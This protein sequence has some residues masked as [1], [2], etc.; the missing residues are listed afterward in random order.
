MVIIFSGFISLSFLFGSWAPQ[1]AYA[2]CTRGTLTDTDCDG[3][4]DNWEV[5]KS[6][7][8]NRD[9]K[10]ISLPGANPNHKNLY[11]EIDFMLPHAPRSD[12]V[13]DVVTAFRNA[14]VFNPDG[15]AG[16]TVNILVDS[17]TP[18][19][20]TSCKNIWADFDAIKRAHIGT[21]A[22]RIA[23]P[24]N[25]YSEKKDVY[26]YGIFIHTQCGNT[27]SSGTAEIPGN[28]FVVSL[29]AP[30]W[31]TDAS[32][33]PVG[34]RDQQA[35]TLMHELGHNL[36]LQHGGN[37]AENCKP[38]YLSVMS[39]SRQFSNYVPGRS[40]DFSRSVIIPYLDESNLNE[41]GGIGVSTPSG[42]Y[43]VIGRS[44]QPS[45]PQTRT[46][47]TGVPINYDWWADSNTTDRNLQS[48]INNLGI[49][50]CNSNTLSPLYGFKDW[51]AIRFWDPSSGG[52]GNGTLMS[53]SIFGNINSTAASPMTEISTNDVLS[54]GNASLANIN[55]S[56]IAKLTFPGFESQPCDPSDP[57]CLQSACDPADP[58]RDLCTF[59][60]FTSPDPTYDDLHGRNVTL[61]ETTIDDVRTSRLSLINEIVQHV[62]A[63]RDQNF[64]NPA[65]ASEFKNG[66][67]AQLNI[68]SQLSQDDKLQDAISN[69]LTL[70]ARMDSAFG[71]SVLDD[72]IVDRGSQEKLV[73]LID[74]FV[75]ALQK[76]M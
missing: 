45:P 11:V 41:G 35:G 1:N 52:I 3:L 23:D 31:G 74:N 63:M 29:G 34:S 26:I 32:G 5:A 46:V 65:F 33:H 75:L 67:V 58:N 72:I 30:G 57:T 71:G 44:N 50:T 10:G 68:V 70:R 48:S 16:V 38:N 13:T 64:S 53:A 6:Y 7:D 66:L 43:T 73:P 62:E 14:P 42:Q 21:S 12:S 39:Y 8:P 15:I 69:M 18:I 24:A 17:T 40:L 76:Q 55:N 49:T 9:G 2:V 22:Q 28:D 19:S 56:T 4:A 60:N 36:K 27:G 59:T 61:L 37:V 25:V 51:T 54:S 47:Q 20:H